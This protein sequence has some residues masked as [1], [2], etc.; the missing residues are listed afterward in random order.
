M[1]CSCAL[2]SVRVFRVRPVFCTAA[3]KK[4]TGG[5]PDCCRSRQ[6]EAMANAAEL[7]RAEVLESS[8]E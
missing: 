6:S 5:G 1:Y 2:E 3:R 7:D 4:A 8:D